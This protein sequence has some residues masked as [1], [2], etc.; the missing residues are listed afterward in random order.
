MPRRKGTPNTPQVVIDEII[1][2]HQNG[3]SLKELAQEYNKPYKTIK[4]MI[5]RENNKKRNISSSKN[6]PKQRGRKPAKTLQELK[7]ENR[8]L[9]MEND[10]MRDFLS[11]TEGK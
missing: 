4:N 11:L 8:C 6:I 7:Y 10:L 3:V 5:T 1:Q 2:K 9:K